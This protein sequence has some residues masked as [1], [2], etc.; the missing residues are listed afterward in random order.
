MFDDEYRYIFIHIIG[1]I[2][3]IFMVFRNCIHINFLFLRSMPP[4]EAIVR[5]FWLQYNFWNC[6]RQK[7]RFWW[8]SMLWSERIFLLCLQKNISNGGIDWSLKLRTI[9]LGLVF[10]LV[11]NKYFVALLHELSRNIHNIIKIWIAYKIL[12]TFFIISC[13]VNYWTNPVTK[14]H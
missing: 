5:D 6:G 14:W 1:D 3:S 11:W 4:N 2:P 8:W 9:F 12:Y 10:Q 7:C 13:I